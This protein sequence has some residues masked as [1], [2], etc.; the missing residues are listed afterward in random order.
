MRSAKLITGPPTAVNS[1]MFIL[2]GPRE[3]VPL[4]FGKP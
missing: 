1:G 4:I 3:M 2:W